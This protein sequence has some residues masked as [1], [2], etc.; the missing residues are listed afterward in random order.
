MC[1]KIRKNIKLFLGGV[2]I[3]FLPDFLHDCCEQYSW[4]YG[5]YL[6]L[7]CMLNSIY[8]SEKYLISGH[9]FQ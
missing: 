4:N 3:D 8:L 5:T 6:L 1:V 9:K 2:R 7:F